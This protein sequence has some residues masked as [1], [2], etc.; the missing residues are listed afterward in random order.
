MDLSSATME[1]SLELENPE[2]VA[3]SIPG[4]KWVD[5][6]RFTFTEA[7]QNNDNLISLQE[8]MMSRIRYLLSSD[9][10]TDDDFKAFFHQIDTDGNDQISW[11][12]LLEEVMCQQKSK[13]ETS[14]NKYI[15]L[16]NEAPSSTVAHQYPISQTIIKM[17]LLPYDDQIVMLTENSLQFWDINTCQ[18]V[19]VFTDNCIFVD[20][21]FIKLMGIIVIARNDRKIIFYDVRKAQKTNIIL[22]PTIDSSIIPCLSMYESKI[23]LRELKQTKI[24]PLFHTP[25]SICAIP[26]F[27]GFLVGNETGQVEAFEFQLSTSDISDFSCHR[28][29]KIKIHSTNI[30]K[31]LYSRAMETYVS[32]SYDGTIALFSLNPKTVDFNI[33]Q[34]IKDPKGFPISNIVIDDRTSE[35]IY[36]TPTHYIGAFHAFQPYIHITETPS[37]L[38]SSMC[39]IT[40]RFSS[41]LFTISV[42]NFVSVYI[43]PT[44]EILTSYF[45]AKHHQKCPPTQSACIAGK[46]F[47]GGAYLSRWNCETSD[48]GTFKPHSDIIT[49]LSVSATLQ[50]VISCDARGS[51]MFWSARTATKALSF[52]CGNDGANVTVMVTDANSR[53]LIFGF[54]NGIMKIV[55]ITTGTVLFQTALKG[56]GSIS[57]IVSGTLNNVR[58]IVCGC[59]RGHVII[60]ED[61]TGNKLKL[62]R[63]IEAHKEPISGIALIKESLILSLGNDKEMF[64][65]TPKSVV[66]HIKYEVSGPTCA[67]DLP[68]NED[69]FIVGDIYGSIHF[70][71]TTVPT[72]FKTI[73]LFTARKRFSVTALTCEDNKICAGN[74]GGYVTLVKMKG[75]EI[76]TLFEHRCNVESVLFISIFSKF[77]TVVTSGDE[78]DIKLFSFDG[79]FIGQIGFNRHF[80]VTDETTWANECP[81]EFDPDDFK[82]PEVENKSEDDLEVNRSL[83]DPRLKP[84]TVVEDSDDDY[85]PV[86]YTTINFGEMVN[87]L[88]SIDEIYKSGNDTARF[89]R[90]SLRIEKKEDEKRGQNLMTFASFF[91]NTQAESNYRRIE[92]LIGKKPAV[93]KFLSP[94]K[95]KRMPI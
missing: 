63:N 82:E 26:D 51:V 68:Y 39:V 40:T 60:F 73:T 11:L 13:T 59:G 23:T 79:P 29:G 74:S 83:S 3:K 57:F 22:S 2:L 46:L 95:K 20:F 21:D 55:S 25:S 87:A 9:P 35:I 31:I 30:T 93:P 61:M 16:N 53:R 28:I 86:T 33:K 72:A 52:E 80:D 81:L 1:T 48:S 14:F 10:M 54:S 17:V 7:D 18:R 70:Y 78:Q 77:R 36:S 32:A 34:T 69:A 90:K 42:N 4:D 67:A 75:D 76:S 41:F 62:T 44:F 66:P 49:G 5:K 50:N 6:L 88:D 19:K 84:A 37:Q 71:N 45:M 8:W 92:G 15:A 89:A 94:T 56:V 91:S 24:P 47:M 58:N 65:W 38:V 43:I 85:Q 12:E 27:K 64:T